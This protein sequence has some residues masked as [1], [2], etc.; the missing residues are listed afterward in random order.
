MGKVYRREK[1]TVLSPHLLEYYL[2]YF[3]FIT[4]FS[5][6]FGSIFFALVSEFKTKQNIF[7]I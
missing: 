7:K 4:S 3:Y 2:I 1:A 6:W 5:T